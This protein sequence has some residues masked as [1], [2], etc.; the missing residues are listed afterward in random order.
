[1]IKLE[2]NTPIIQDTKP[3]IVKIFRFSADELHGI[4]SDAITHIPSNIIHLSIVEVLTSHLY[5]H[6]VLT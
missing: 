4:K 3:T 6:V 2:E 1:M 5:R